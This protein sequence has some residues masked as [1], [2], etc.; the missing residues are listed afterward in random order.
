MLVKQKLRNMK[1]KLPCETYFDAGIH[2][3]H[4]EGLLHR[5]LKPDNMGILS[6]DQPF[7]VLFDLGMTKMYTNEEGQ[8]S[9]ML[10]V[11]QKII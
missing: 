9:S 1:Y 8:V 4:R 10:I 2:D 3:M 6:K 7:V 5:D 11:A